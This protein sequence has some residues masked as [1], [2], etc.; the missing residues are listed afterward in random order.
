[1]NISNSGM[2]AYDLVVEYFLLLKMFACIL[3]TSYRRIF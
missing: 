3:G 2:Y 1:M